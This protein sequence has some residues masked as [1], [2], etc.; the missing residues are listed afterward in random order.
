MNDST[1]RWLDMP[2]LCASIVLCATTLFY[3]WRVK[4]VEERVKKEVEEKASLTSC[5]VRDWTQADRVVHIP[6]SCITTLDDFYFML[7]KRLKIESARPIKLYLLQAEFRWLEARTK[8]DSTAAL[9]SALLAVRTFEESLASLDD[10]VSELRDMNSRTEILFH[11]SALSPDVLTLARHDKSTPL[12]NVNLFRD[13]GSGRSRGRGRGKGK[14]GGRGTPSLSSSSAIDLSTDSSTVSSASRSSVRNSSEQK[15][16]REQLMIREEKKCLICSVS[17]ECDENVQ[18]EA[19]HIIPFREATTIEVADYGLSTIHDS[20]NGLLLCRSCHKLYD[21]DIVGVDEHGLIHVCGA[22]LNSGFEKWPWV[23]HTA[24][25]QP[26]RAIHH[27]DGAPFQ[28]P[29]VWQNE[30]LSASRG[31]G[32]TELL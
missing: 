9:Q 18:L 28:T 23:H 29:F 15:K 21:R 5:P 22:L 10:A 16:F 4:E 26:S 2:L 11:L 12:P 6:C 24:A 3:Y 8:I 32:E 30:R 27:E 25:C 17:G 19:A 1:P 20:S 14:S 7:R 31:G 13:S